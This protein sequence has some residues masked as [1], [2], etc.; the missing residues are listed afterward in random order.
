LRAGVIDVGTNSVKLAIGE[1]EVGGFRSILDASINARLGEGV[2]ETGEINRDAQDRT[3]R[4]V[5]KHIQAARSLDTD[6]LRIVATSA[7]RDAANT[8]QFANRMRAELGVGLEV[9]SEADECRYSFRAVAL[10]PGMGNRDESRVVADVGGGSTEIIAGR[11]AEVSLSG[12]LKIGAVRLTERFIGEDPPSPGEL[13]RASEHAHAEIARLADG[14]SADTTVGV[15]GSAVNLARI[16]LEL[17]PGRT[18]EAHG[19]VMLREEV[20]Q[21]WR[22][23]AEMPLAE[24]TTVVGLEP[25]R[26][27]IIVAGILI[28][29]RVMEVFGSSRLAVSTRGLRYGVLYEMLAAAT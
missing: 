29:D 21:T 18:P 6:N 22:R 8:G 16:H 5:S 19:T 10:D 1:S 20:K 25:E 3:I 11:L 4:A 24:R 9:L 13:M 15:G 17:A 23:L 27:D 12:S 26:A 2:D 14:F 7:A 28:I